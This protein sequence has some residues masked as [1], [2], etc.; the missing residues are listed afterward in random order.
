MDTKIKAH[1]AN[2][3]K[4]FVV[5]VNA[6]ENFGLAVIERN[7]GAYGEVIQRMRRVADRRDP[8]APDAAIDGNRRL[9]G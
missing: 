2:P 3:Q 1:E 4:G 8:S 9:S 6:S 7:L 5:Q